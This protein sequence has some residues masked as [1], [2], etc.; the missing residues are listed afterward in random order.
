MVTKPKGLGRGIDALLAGSL[1]DPAANASATLTELA[2]AALAPG[3]YQ[4][5]TRMDPA[6][7]DEL[8]ASIRVQGVIQPIIVR[9]LPTATPAG[10]THEILAGERRWRAAM[11]AGLATVPVVVRPVPDEAALGIGLIEN[12][13]REDLNAIEEAQGIRRLID[14]FNLTHEQVAD[15]IGRSRAA[16]S[17]LLR[18]LELTRPVKQMLE[19]GALEM[20][21]ARALLGLTDANQVTAATEVVTRKLSVRDTEKLVQNRVAA[22]K[23][24][25]RQ[26]KETFDADTRKLEEELAETIGAYVTIRHDASGKGELMIR[27]ASLDQLDGILDRLR[28]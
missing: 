3:R 19:E 4:P 5:R 14:E 13:Q 2:I 10:A 7:L 15:A 24:K 28:R 17:N 16:V 20:G 21:H 8:A 23:G 11:K 18:L 6:A 1:S 12:I 9:P 22:P 25:R 27:Y 26:G